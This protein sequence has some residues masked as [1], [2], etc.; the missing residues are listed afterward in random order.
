MNGNVFC[1]ILVFGCIYIHTYVETYMHMYIGRSV[2]FVVCALNFSNMTRSA[3]RLSVRRLPVVQITSRSWVVVAWP[4][5]LSLACYDYFIYFV[6]SL[7][8]LFQ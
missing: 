6:Y 7:C 5:C 8:A 4:L 1:F 3:D 2:G